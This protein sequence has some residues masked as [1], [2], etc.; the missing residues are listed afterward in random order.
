MKKKEHQMCFHGT[1]D[2]EMEEEAPEHLSVRVFLDA[3]DDPIIQ[4]AKWVS[5]GE[6]TLAPSML[7]HH[8]H[9]DCMRELCQ[10]LNRHM[11]RASLQGTQGTQGALGLMRSSR[12]R[13][14]SWGCSAS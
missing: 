2:E 5:Q 14:C 7:S 9:N 4:V 1:Q 3:M 13:R 12:S 11:A 8:Q 10:E 6:W